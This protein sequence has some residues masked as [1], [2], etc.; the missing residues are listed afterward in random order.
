M[1]QYFATL[2]VDQFLPEVEKRIKN[3]NGFVEKTGR[4][5]RALKSERLYFG[6]HLGEIGV[7]SGDSTDVGS[8]GAL[9]AYGVNHY[10]NLVKHVM[11]LTTS[12]KP[13]YDPQA[14]NS[15]LKSMQQA[16]LAS[17]ILDNYLSEKRMGRHM[18]AAAERSLVGGKAYAFMTWEPSL[19]KPAGT[20][21]ISDKSGQPILDAN[22]V[23]KE[24]VVYE[25]DVMITSKGWRDVI[26]DPS[27][28]DWEHKKWV[29]VRN[30]ENK[31]DLAARY[32]EYA[33]QIVELGAHDDLAERTAAQDDSTK[34]MQD[35]ESGSDLIPTYRLYHLKTDA[36]PNG[37][38]S[39]FLNGGISLYDGPMPYRRLPVFRITPGE[40][41]DSAEGYTDAFDVMVL[42][43]VLNV[44]YSIPFTNQQAFAVQNVWMPD[45]CEVSTSQMNGSG[46]NIF[47][48]GLP[49]TEPKAIQLTATPAELFK[50]CE[51]VESAM[52]KL[53]GLNDT[54]RGDPEHNLK[55]AVALGR[56]QAMAIQYASNFQKSWA[57]L[58]EDC[59]TFLLELLQDFAKT[60]RMAA[61]AGA[62]NKGA[63]ISFTGDDLSQIKRVSV[64]LGNPLSRTAA[65][66]LELADKLLDKGEINGKQYIEVAATGSL[67]PVFES[68]V[69][70]P[71]LIQKENEM[72]MDGK[73]VK[74]MVG[75]PHKA[76]VREHKATMD[77]PMLRSL[78]AAGDPQ[79][80]KIVTEIQD[81]MREHMQLEQ[82]QDPFWFAVSGEQ[83]PPP[84]P[85]PP[86]GVQG[87]GGPPPSNG[88]PGPPPGG[89][90]MPPPEMGP[91]MNASPPP[92]P[93]LPPE[94]KHPPMPMG[95]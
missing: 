63:M 18:S 51:M 78:V 70:G 3:F 9:T 21:K 13:S 5:K 7:S 73:P 26:Y 79:A 2:P 39:Y 56:M 64:D 15:D 84:P 91:P 49:G 62:R 37:R 69:S 58:Q 85:G 66:R 41:F 25:G 27:L 60:S 77:D 67:D 34:Y 82:T 89:G 74:A 68:E 45:G 55:S 95:A 80:I 65:G 35:G 93:P 16:R 30:Y 83:P 59:G 14:E 94:L 12:Q 42:Q 92:I 19:G 52:V 1:N 22:G 46:L 28:R 75:D 8:D 53:M 40:E 33:D 11:A 17:N 48:G 61:M 76:H 6:R 10:R 50:N 31:W 23:H 36:M 43:Q 72:L 44:L 4:A 20:Q 38:Y 86:P 47:K 87:P 29:V 54:V 32:S 81:H 90:G 57:E 71:E 88:P 24:K